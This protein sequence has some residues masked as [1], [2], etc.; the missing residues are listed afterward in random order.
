MGDEKVR[1]YRHALKC[2]ER[3]GVGANRVV[4][5][6]MITIQQQVKLIKI[7]Y[8]LTN[9]MRKSWKFLS[10]KIFLESTTVYT[11]LV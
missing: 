4:L 10:V 6:S 1:I 11:F 3:A 7:Q 2:R 8:F 9:D 5:Q